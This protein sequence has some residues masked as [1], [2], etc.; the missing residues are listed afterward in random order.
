[1]ARTPATDCYT[2]VRRVAVAAKRLSHGPLTG[3]LRNRQCGAERIITKSRCSPRSPVEASHVV[4]AAPK[5]ASCF[6]K[7]MVC[8]FESMQDKMQDTIPPRKEQKLLE[9]L[10]LR[11]RVGRGQKTKNK[12]QARFGRHYK[13]Y[14]YC[15]VLRPKRLSYV[16]GLFQIPQI[17]IIILQAQQQQ[18]QQR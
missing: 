7:Q 10:P 4:G 16:S 2:N 11:F 17:L 1:M 9:T 13:Y 6:S 12:K 18:Q 15:T 5:I 3:R 14:T 8:F